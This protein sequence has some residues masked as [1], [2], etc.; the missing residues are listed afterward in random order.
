MFIDIN[1]A[2]ALT[3]LFFFAGGGYVFTLVK[4]GLSFKQNLRWEMMFA[5]M[6]VVLSCF[7]YGLMTIAVHDTLMKVLWIM[8]FISYNLF[9]PSWIR[10]TS[11]MI[12]I[13]NKIVIFTTKFLLIPLTAVFTVICIFSNDT[14]FV[15]TSIGNQI[16]YNGSLI[17]KLMTIYVFLLCVGVFI[18]HIRWWLESDMKRQRNQQRTFLILT[19]IF[20]PAGFAT[21]YFIPAFTAFPAPPLVSILLFPASFQLFMSMRLNKT[22]RITVPMISDYIFKSIPIPVF[23]LDHKNKISL[24]NNFTYEFFGT[25]IINKNI[26]DFIMSDSGTLEESFFDN[27]LVGKSVSVLTASGARTCEM[28]LNVERD[29]FDEAICKVVLLSDITEIIYRNELLL[30]TNRAADF[31]LYSDTTLFNENLIKAMQVMGDAADVF[32][33]NIC[34][35]QIIKDKL[36]FANLF[37]WPEAFLKD[38]KGAAIPYTVFPPGWETNLANGKC[39]NI[40]VNDMN[41]KAREFLAKQ[42]IF[43]M[44]LVPIFFQ[45][46]FWGFVSFSDCNRE[47]IF[48]SEEET[49]LR[50][51]GLLFANALLRYEAELEIEKAGELTKMMLDSSPFSCQIWDRNID[52]LDCN[53]AAVRLFKFKDKQEFIDRFK[54][55][56]SPEYQPCGKTS[57][58][59]VLY[60][61][62]KVFKEGRCVFDWMHRISDG[63]LMPAEVTLSRVKYKDDYVVVGYVL[64]LREVKA[65]EQKMR[66]S[67]ERERDLEV[68]KQVAQAADEAKT[69]FLAHMSHEIRTPMNAIIGMSDLL[70]SE[71]L[72]NRPHRYAE[73]IKISSM[74]LLN[75]INDILDLTK[76]QAAKLNLVPVHYDFNGF[77]ENICSMTTFLITNKSL[78]EKTGKLD[79]T[80]DIDE[81]IPE[82]I[83]GDDVR[84]RQILL[85]LLSNAVKYTNEGGITLSIRVE[86][87]NLLITI[88]DTGMGIPAEDVPTLFEAFVRVDTEKNRKTQ[89]TGLGLTITKSLVDLMDGQIMVES[90]YGEGTTF[91]INLPFII[92][93]KS[94]IKFE[95]EMIDKVYAPDVNVLVVDDRET[96][97]SVICGLL[98]HCHI[99][100]D[101]AISG[102]EAIEMAK[103]KQYELIFM[104]HMM[105][106]MDGIEATKILRDMGITIPIVALTANVV[107]GAKELLLSAGMDDFLAKPIDKSE[108]YRVLGTWINPEKLIHHIPESDEN[109]VS[110]QEESAFWEILSGINGLQVDIGLDLASGQEKVYISTLE[111]SLNEIEKS[112]IRLNG[113]SLDKDLNDFRIEVHGLKGSL[114]CIGGTELAGKARNLENAATRDDIDFCEENRSQFVENLASFASELKNAFEAL[115][116][117]QN[118]EIP[119]ELKL[120]L[121]R[122]AEAMESTDFSALYEEIDLLDGMEFS[123]ALNDEIENLKSAVLIMDYDTGGRIITRLMKM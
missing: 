123:E 76:V 56:A 99:I 12:S 73:D 48:T 100:A 84:L 111:I 101:A 16:T 94:L 42:G 79:F 69:Q 87:S 70:L 28:M 112:I 106:E 45:D 82:C 115:R 40:L 97:L 64:D 39:V 41:V 114:S 6:C 37:G 98:Q 96:N 18:A 60:Y 4:E 53:E 58:E 120:V 121:T 24:A 54:Y 9:L 68:Q 77:I 57:Y 44:L 122:M 49:I 23:V 14:V 117:N 10:F 30:A 21:D 1:P 55:E 19:F 25:S 71:N 113:Y 118:F 3:L 33:I 78:L 119:D 103:A 75:I 31:L 108:L 85:N 50:S 47:Q 8:G 109:D 29:K 107:S 93:D 61:V 67:L 88:S 91:K 89:G 72:D 36:Y 116:K 20:A 65:A 7:F 5:V 104:D 86:D 34:K 105:P 32:N 62:D 2:Y 27:N 46:R 63:E 26:T 90:E 110:T 35:N 83:Y 102:A 22:L 43:A 66:E 81:K 74:S 59:L 80:V 17:F 51:C 15:K 92:G 11:N 38:R 13:K 95:Q 52:I